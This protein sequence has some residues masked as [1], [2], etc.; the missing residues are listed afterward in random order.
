MRGSCNL[1][2]SL[3]SMIPEHKHPL[4]TGACNIVVSF[5]KAFTKKGFVFMLASSLLTALSSRGRLCSGASS[6]PTH[7][8]IQNPH[9][10]HPPHRHSDL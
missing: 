9:P 7:S 5:I 6:F 1:S 3:S 8:Q 10:R 2:A 4:S